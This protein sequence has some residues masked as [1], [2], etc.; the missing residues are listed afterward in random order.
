AAARMQAAG[1]AP[2]AE[3][4]RTTGR[5][6]VAIIPVID[7]AGLTVLLSHVDTRHHPAAIRPGDRKAVVHLTERFGEHD[8]V[9]RPVADVVD[10]RAAVD[11]EHP[12][13]TERPNADFGPG[14][15]DTHPVL[16]HVTLRITVQHIV[17]MR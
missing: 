14:R 12:E 2:V 15:G 10:A 7:P 11:A 13:A 5:W 4:T 16:L 3:P 1:G 17:R 9:A 8:R 6:V